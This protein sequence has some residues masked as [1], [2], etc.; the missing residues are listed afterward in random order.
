MKKLT[1]FGS[2]L[3]K[4]I[5]IIFSVY[6]LAALFLFDY[7][8]PDFL[9]S[10]AAQPSE[11]TPV[12]AESSD[13]TE[14][15]YNIQFD[16]DTL[17]YDGSSKLDLLEGV[18]ITAA[19]GSTYDAEIFARINTGD[20]LTE[21]EV[22]YTADLPD[23]QISATRPLILKNYTGPSITLP[24]ELPDMEED[25]LSEL[26]EHMPSDGSFSA[27]DGFG[28]DLTDS[29]DISYTVDENNPSIIHYI[30]T[31]TNLYN[32]TTSVSAD[33]TIDSSRP[34]LVLSQKEVTISQNSQFQAL[35]YVEKAE[36]SEGNSLFHRIDIHGEL[37]V[38]TPGTYTLTY[39]VSTT[40]GVSSAPQT[41]TVTV[42]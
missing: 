16:S 22:I 17:T 25:N 28:N 19:D 42:E 29:V 38:N 7:Q 33:L 30:F 10:D 41:L 14:T 23:G 32:D 27:D 31:V 1:T 5:I 35:N 8:L 34:I 26:L 21:K 13:N 39:V 9:S 6:N 20:S 18:S 15:S 37:D 36:D 11:S 24:S 40:D 2:K 4:F 3:F 12:E